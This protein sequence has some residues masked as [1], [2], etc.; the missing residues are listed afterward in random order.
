PVSS[1]A[2][3][4]QMYDPYDPSVA[5]PLETE[6]M[7]SRGEHRD[8]TIGGVYGTA[9]RLHGRKDRPPRPHS[10]PL[11]GRDRPG[12]HDQRGGPGV[13]PVLHLPSSARRGPSSRTLGVPKKWNAS[14]CRGG[15]DVP[16]FG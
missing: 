1:H 6:T 4:D 15:R 12:N 14:G 11:R 13:H 7:G 10:H 2:G 5:P 16:L 3:G 8:G 9:V